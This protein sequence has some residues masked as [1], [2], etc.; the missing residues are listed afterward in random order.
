MQERDGEW[1][2]YFSSVLSWNPRQVLKDYLHPSWHVLYA[3]CLCKSHSFD[4]KN[5]C[6]QVGRL[7]PC[8]SP[9]PWTPLPEAQP[10]ANTPKSDFTLLWGAV[11]SMLDSP[12]ARVPGDRGEGGHGGFPLVQEGTGCFGD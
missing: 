3:Q 12:Q 6:E 9:H 8:G 1:A 4:L 2:A 5:L 7:T 10:V 11:S